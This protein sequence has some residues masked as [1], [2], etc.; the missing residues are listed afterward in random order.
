MI[1]HGGYLYGFDGSFLACV[2]LE[3]GKKQWKQRGYGNGQI[4]LLADQ[5]LLLVLS[6]KGEAALV[7]A[8]PEAAKELGRFQAVEGKTWNHPVVAH[9]RLF[10]RNGREAACYELTPQPSLDQGK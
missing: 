2:S 9:G 10:I 5:D 4:L 7:Q 1:A 3:D 6:E 8:R